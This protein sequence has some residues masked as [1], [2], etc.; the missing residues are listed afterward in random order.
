MKP[1]MSRRALSLLAA[2]GVVVAC[3]APTDPPQEGTIIVTFPSVSAALATDTLQLEVF[4]A[5]EASTC[6]ELVEKRKTGQ[7]L[8]KP[9]VERL[10]IPTCTFVDNKAAP[11]DVGYGRRAFLVVG[12]G[13][14][15]AAGPGSSARLPQPCLIG[16]ALQGVGNAK[17]TVDV[18]LTLFSNT[19]DVPAT[20]CTQLSVKCRGGCN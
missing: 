5:P 6:L 16:C 11:L 15:R 9:L 1:K 2:S 19:V 14:G 13:C 7:D 3:S 17:I 18:P 12:V 4:D 10:P 8:P 20:T